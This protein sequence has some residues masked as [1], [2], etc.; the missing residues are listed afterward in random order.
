MANYLEFEEPLAAIEEEIQKAKDI[1]TNSGVDTSKM[2]KD[3]EK[4]LN[5][6]T[7]DIFEIVR[8]L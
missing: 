1:E 4:K 7:K 5:S 6:S 2:V 8:I 3:L